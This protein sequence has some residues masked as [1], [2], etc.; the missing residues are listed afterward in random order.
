M[1]EFESRANSQEDSNSIPDEKKGGEPKKKRR[2]AVRIKVKSLPMLIAIVAAIAAAGYLIPAVVLPLLLPPP[3]NQ[4]FSAS[5]LEEVVNINKLSTVDFYYSGIAE[6]HRQNDGAKSQRAVDFRIR[7]TANIRV[8]FNMSEIS[9]GQPN[10]EAK[11]I[12]VHLPEPLIEISGI[13]PSSISYLPEGRKN[14]ELAEVI[15]LCREDATREVREDVQVNE[16]AYSNLEDTI[17]G[18]T[19]P[20]VGN[21]YTLVFVRP[22][23]E[24]VDIESSESEEAGSD[25]TESAMEEEVANDEAQN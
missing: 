25:A 7:Y 18:L 8:S 23:D 24:G 20:I 2:R 12:T 17:K 15:S 21:E 14:V 1:G 22:S 13:D 19:L 6:K 9:F 4:H 5:A 11:T 10:E 16:R 3:E